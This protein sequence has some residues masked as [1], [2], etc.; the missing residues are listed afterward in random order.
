LHEATAIQGDPMPEDELLDVV[1]R[2]DH[3]I[4][5]RRRSE[6]YAEN[7]S[8]FRAIN[9][10]LVNDQG[11]VWLPRRTVWKQLYPLCLD[12]SC[13]GHV[14]SGESYEDALKRE[15]K[16]ELNLDLE[17][18]PCRL[19]GYLTPYDDGVSMFMK[20]YEIHDHRTPE[21]NREILS[22]RS[23]SRPKKSWSGFGWANW[24]KMIY[25]N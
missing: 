17:Q 7:S 5:Q 1:D 22:R 11:Q 18:V 15:L 2:D 20:V 23:G 25:P 6:L 19:L 8:D 16:E 4:G 9:V 13:A 12:M 24:L 3:V 10:F 21:W 14:K